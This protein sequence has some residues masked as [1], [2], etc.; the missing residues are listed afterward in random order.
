MAELSDWYKV[1]FDD[2]VVR[3]EVSPPDGEAWVDEFAWA[4]VVRVCFK[5]GSAFESDEV[6]VFT[7]ERPESYVVPTEAD[8]GRALV[9]EIVRRD[10]FA[11]ELMVEA[12]RTTEPAIYCWPPVEGGQG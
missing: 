12:A 10:L 3:R 7:S 1:S 2:R 4:D 8:G 6:Y 9:E 5:T 11:A